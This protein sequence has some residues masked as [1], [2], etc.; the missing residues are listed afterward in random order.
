MLVGVPADVVGRLVA[1]LAEGV[2]RNLDTQ[3]IEPQIWK[4]AL[5]TEGV[6]RNT[7]SEGSAKVAG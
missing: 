2:D 3:W 7:K 1:L 6:D 5:L 4:V